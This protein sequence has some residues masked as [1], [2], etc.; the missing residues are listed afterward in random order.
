[1]SLKYLKEGT[2]LPESLLLFS[3]DASSVSDIFPTPFFKIFHLYGN[4]IKLISEPEELNSPFKRALTGFSKK[5][6]IVGVRNS[7]VPL[8]FNHPLTLD[9]GLKVVFYVECDFYVEDDKA[10]VKK[11]GGTDEAFY[12]DSWMQT[13]KAN[14]D[15]NL[16]RIGSVKNMSNIANVINVEVNNYFLDIGCGINVKLLIS[17]DSLEKSDHEKLKDEIKLANAGKAFKL[18]EDFKFNKLEFVLKTKLKVVEL[19]SV[20]EIMDATNIAEGATHGLDLIRVDRQA[21]L[22]QKKLKKENELKKL[23]GELAVQEAGNHVRAQWARLDAGKGKHEHTESDAGKNVNETTAAKA[24]EANAVPPIVLE[25][26]NLYTN[27]VTFVTNQNATAPLSIRDFGRYFWQALEEKE[28]RIKYMLSN[29]AVKS[30]S[31]S[32]PYLNEAGSIAL[33]L[34]LMAHLYSLPGMSRH[35]IALLFVQNKE[36]NEMDNNNEES[37]QRIL[38]S[39]LRKE[40]LFKGLQKM[41]SVANVAF[42]W[43]PVHDR[44]LVIEFVNHAKIVVNL[45]MGFACWGVKLASPKPESEAE[46]MG[47]IT[48][49]ANTFKLKQRTTTLAFHLFCPN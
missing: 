36:K 15:N 49:P 13:V 43:R 30:I 45:S 31:Y 35:V 14:I 4:E 34:N 44:E 16:E 8:K 26:L 24:I 42:E 11:F 29:Y 7:S 3:G 28:P 37:K 19:N 10:F 22:E 39:K 38:P 32:E 6:R 27:A 33:Y 47:W 1:M 5:G 23:Q 9:D 48:N 40:F 46:L 17:I 41:S 18:I 25:S 21:E 12:A 2:L 20:P